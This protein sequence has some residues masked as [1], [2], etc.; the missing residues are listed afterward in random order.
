MTTFELIHNVTTVLALTAFLVLI[1][2]YMT[3]WIRDKQ[4]T[5]FGVLAIGLSGVI[6]KREGLIYYI[7]FET[8]II[9][10]LGAMLYKHVL[11]IHLA[12]DIL[13]IATEI[14]FITSLTALLLSYLRHR[15]TI[16]QGK[17]E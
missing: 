8:S 4:H 1:T 10:F 15:K 9:L 3:I 5:P 11:N 6:M 2:L 7:M 17:Q 12:Y 13:E 14:L 16:V